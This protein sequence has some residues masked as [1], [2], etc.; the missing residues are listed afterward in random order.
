MD[1]RQERTWARLDE[2]VHSVARR[3]PIREVTVAELAQTAG[4]SRDTFYRHA[5]GA[6]EL[7]AEVLRR[8]IARLTAE[9]ASRAQRSGGRELFGPAEQ[10]LLEHM[11]EHREIYLNAMSPRLI[12]PLRDMLVA[13]LEEGL[14][15]YLA[16]FPDVAPP[17]V[18]GFT[19]EES[20]RIYA[21][22]AASGTVG[23]IEQWLISGAVASPEQTAQA[24]LAASPEW[25][26]RD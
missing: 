16:R 26:L 8:E 2:A 15:D 23:A 6:P 25:W 24:I 12:S 18:E 17:P 13:Q 1:P 19:A 10:A 11:V 5:A 22:Y 14:A 4:V 9:F 21:A 3:K 7:L 20:R